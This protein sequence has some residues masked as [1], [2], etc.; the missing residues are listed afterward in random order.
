MKILQ[1]TFKKD[2]YTAKYAYWSGIGIEALPSG[3]PVLANVDVH[4]KEKV[5]VYQTPWYVKTSQLDCDA[6]MLSNE[7]F[8][9]LTVTVNGTLYV[10]P[11]MTSKVVP[12]SIVI[13]EAFLELCHEHAI[14][15][16]KDAS[17][18]YVSLSRLSW[19]T[20]VNAFMEAI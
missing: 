15:D 2:S 3:E 19:Q 13:T 17:K 7:T 6:I 8:Y 14:Y 10:V 5:Y 11:G 18:A 16:L 12:A 20:G 1:I 9:D 4:Q